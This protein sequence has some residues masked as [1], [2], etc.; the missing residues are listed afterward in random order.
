M[1]DEHKSYE[2]SKKSF[3]DR[4]RSTAPGTDRETAR[5]IA[6]KSARDLHDKLDKRR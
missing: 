4:I 2:Q 1:A 5:R 3:E 6:E